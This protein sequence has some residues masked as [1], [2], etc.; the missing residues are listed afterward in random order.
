MTELA[1]RSFTIELPRDLDAITI[2]AKQVSSWQRRNC[3]WQ[4]ASAHGRRRQLCSQKCANGV[5]FPDK[6]Q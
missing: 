2:D 3:A 4:S 5:V 1:A 6:A